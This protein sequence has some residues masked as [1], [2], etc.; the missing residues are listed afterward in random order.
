MQYQ[1]FLILYYPKSD[2]SSLDQVTITQTTQVSLLPDTPFHTTNFH[3]KMNLVHSNMPNF[4]ETHELWFKKLLKSEWKYSMFGN[5]DK[6]NNSR[7]WIATFLLSYL[8]RDTTFIP[9]NFELNVELTDGYNKY[10]LLVCCFAC[11]R[12][13][14]CD[15][16]MRW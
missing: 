8:P 9:Y 10:V 5:Y 12:L 14:Q 1:Q 3:I 7:T 6:M 13:M 16:I 11:H 2:S 15:Q 4:I